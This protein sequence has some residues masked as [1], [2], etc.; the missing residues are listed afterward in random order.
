[1]IRLAVELVN[2]KSDGFFDDLAPQVFFELTE[3][4][5]ECSEEGGAEGIERLDESLQTKTNATSTVLSAIIG[6][7]CS[8]GRLVV[9]Y[10]LLFLVSNVR[11]ACAHSCAQH[12]GVELRQ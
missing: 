6:P 3:D 9:L 4:A 10:L 8:S 11:S 12:W 5:W 1:M 2:N 7:P